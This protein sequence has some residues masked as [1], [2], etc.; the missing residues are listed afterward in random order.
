MYIKVILALVAVTA[1]IITSAEADEPTWL[2]TVPKAETLEEGYYTL[3]FIYAD[4]GIAENLEIGLHGLKYSMPE[5]NLAFGISLFP[6]AT[7]YLVLTP[8]AG[9]GK[10]HMGVK[11][12]PYIFFAGLETPISDRVKF[13]AELN[14]GIGAGV[15]ISLE[16]DWT[17]DLFAAFMTLQPYKYRYGLVEIEDFYPI[18]GIL[19]AYSG[20]M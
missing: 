13:V 15:R 10:L 14:N 8:D 7:P 3:G 4:F 11:A 2:F 1:I 19:V 17:L 16:R 9:S 12:A 6:L 20:R 18:P 5:S